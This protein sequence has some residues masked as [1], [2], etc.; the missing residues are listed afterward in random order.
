MTRLAA[1]ASFW[2]LLEQVVIC[3]A[4]C[5]MPLQGPHPLSSQNKAPTASG[6]FLV[7]C[8]CLSA[9]NAI[10]MA[11]HRQCNAQMSLPASA[12]ILL[13]SFFFSPLCAA[14]LRAISELPAVPGWP[15]LRQPS[16]WASHACSCF[17]CSLIFSVTSQA[18]PAAILDRCDRLPCF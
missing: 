1:P 7:C 13:T 10:A 17:S 12:R 2:L 3:A 11:W 8:S 9:S 18:D 15:W 5:W 14:L 6:I 16:D 4:G